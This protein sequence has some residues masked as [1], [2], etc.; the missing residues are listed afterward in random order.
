MENDNI[1]QM[2]IS[3]QKDILWFESNLK[4]L[5]DKYNNKFIAIYDNKVIESDYNLDNL[6]KKLKNL[7]IDL[8]VVFIKFISQ[9]KTI[10]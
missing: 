3:G 5:K 7:S 6:L 1:A 10:L 9:V 2:L 4:G 8:S